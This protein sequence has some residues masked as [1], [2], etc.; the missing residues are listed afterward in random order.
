MKV[1]AYA[2]SVVDMFDGSETIY[3][4]TSR[5]QAKVEHFHRVRDAWPDIEFTAVRARKIG[6]AHTS[7]AF[8]HVAQR[9]GMPDARCGQK[10]NIGAETAVIVGHNDSMNFNVL[11]E[12]GRF[13]GK[14]LNVHPLDV[15]I[16]P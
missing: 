1:S 14:I 6:D 3:N 12:T 9:R 4:A 11:F 7:A 13:A 8:L 16:A 2:C 5:G 15:R 10:V